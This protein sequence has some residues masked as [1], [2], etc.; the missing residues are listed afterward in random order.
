MDT[1]KLIEYIVGVLLV[2]ILLPVLAQV[3]NESLG[4]YSSSVKYI[5]VLLPLFIII[6]LALGTFYVM[7]HRK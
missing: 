1:T 4:N 3:I 6:A 5:I 7:K 2:V